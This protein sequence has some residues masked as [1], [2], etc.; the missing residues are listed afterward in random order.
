[1]S[2]NPDWDRWIRASVNTYLSD[3]LT[4]LKIFPDGS[5][6]T[7]KSGKQD[8]IEL[9]MDGPHY[10]GMPNNEW[11]LTIE[12]NVLVCSLINEQN[13]YRHR[14]IAGRIAKLLHSPIT[15]YK[16]PEDSAYSLGCLKMDAID[17]HYY[18]RVGKNIPMKQ[19]T[20]DCFG[21]IDL[22]GE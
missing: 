1:M 7:D 14:G 2:I 11:R 22:T 3:N 21:T 18:E 16:M 4:D 12:I 6:D 20:L 19:A 17:T 9:R 10:V 13:I 8:W 5:P 15:I